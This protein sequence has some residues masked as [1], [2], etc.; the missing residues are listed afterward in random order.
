M[1]GVVLLGA[2]AH[3]LGWLLARRRTARLVW[4]AWNVLGALFLGLGV[5]GMAYAWGALGLQSGLGQSPPRRWGSSSP[6]RGS[7]CWSRSECGRSSAAGGAGVQCAHSPVAQPVEQV[8]V[9]LAASRPKGGMEKR[10]NS[11]N[12]TSGR[13][14]EP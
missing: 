1:G 7:G 3:A 4:R 9:E 10:A 13:I 8:A 11:G 5:L 12:P 14:G 6:R 2:L